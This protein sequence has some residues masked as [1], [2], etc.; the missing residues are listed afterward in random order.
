MKTIIEKT[1]SRERGIIEARLKKAEARINPFP[2]ELFIGG[3][4]ISAERMEV[5]E[6]AEMNGVT[7]A[8]AK[9]LMVERKEMEHR[10]EVLKWELARRT[11]V[12]RAAKEVKRAK[13]VRM[14][15]ATAAEVGSFGDLAKVLEARRYL[16]EETEARESVGDRIRM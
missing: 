16:A 1:V 14:I 9:R 13:R 11:D 2:G 4:V 3:V 10:A 6:F 12:R 5:L 8:E 15:E 7:E